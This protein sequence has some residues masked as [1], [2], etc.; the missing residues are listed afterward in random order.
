MKA[1]VMSEV[2][3]LDIEKPIHIKIL[4]GRC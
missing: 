3:W 4:R 1:K 2:E